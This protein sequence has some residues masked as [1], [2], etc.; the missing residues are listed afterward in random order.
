MLFHLR[1]YDPIGRNL[2]RPTS[3][4][5]PDSSYYTGDF[6]YS[7]MNECFFMTPAYY[8]ITTSG[9]GNLVYET[10]GAPTNPSKFQ[11]YGTQTAGPT[12]SIGDLDQFYANL[13]FVRRVDYLRVSV[14]RWVDAGYTSP[15]SD[16]TTFKTELCTQIKDAVALNSYLSGYDEFNVVIDNNFNY[17]AFYYPGNDPNADE[18]IEIT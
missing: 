11:C 15:D 1:N 17:L 4:S 16:Y 14:P 9:S 6:D 13:T 3:Q 7:K 5:S 2:F 8:E 10:Y 18:V 12:T